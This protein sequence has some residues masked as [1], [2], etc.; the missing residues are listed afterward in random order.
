MSVQYWTFAVRLHFDSTMPYGPKQYDE[1]VAAIR[2][3]L[4]VAVEGSKDG[5]DP[6]IFERVSSVEVS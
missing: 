3:A 1:L 4:E 5:S 2:S 6:K